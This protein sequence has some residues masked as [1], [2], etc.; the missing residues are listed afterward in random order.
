MEINKLYCAD[1][2]EFVKFMPSEFVDMVM[3][4][5]PYWGLRDYGIEGQWGLEEHPKLFIERMVILFRE[6]KR[7]LKKTGS[8]YLNLG[9]TYFS[10]PA[11]NTVERMTEEGFGTYS[12]VESQIAMKRRKLPQ[13]SN[14]LQPKQLMLMPHRVAIAL[15]EDGWICRNGI[16][17]AKPN[18]MPSSV[19]D[20]LNNT[21]E[22]LFH[23]VKS[24][25]YY[26]DLDAIREQW[27]DERISDIKRAKE[28]HPGY[29]GKRSEFTAQGIKGQPVGNPELGKN[30]GDVYWMDKQENP[31]ELRK[32]L[33]ISYKEKWDNPLGKNPGDIFEITTQPFPHAHFAVFPEALCEKPIKSSCPSDG[34]VFDPFVGSGTTCV[35]AKKLGRNWIGCDISPEY[36]QLAEKRLRGY[37][38]LHFK[39]EK[40][41]RE[42]TAFFGGERG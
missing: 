20:R 29:F 6:I 26:Y 18:P 31:R 33:G 37:S 25:K 5:P 15:Q 1:V 7:V 2:L 13:K 4:S 38:A 42:L 28:N 8:V 39:E 34:V 36:I 30:P 24:R 19:K 41:T 32:Q 23:F 3:T 9:D 17:W 27:T 22:M 11:G 21:Y 16:V 12:R 40:I 35:V 10:S 14:W